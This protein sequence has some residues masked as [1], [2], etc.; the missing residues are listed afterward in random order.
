MHLLLKTDIGLHN[1]LITAEEKREMFDH[2]AD[3]GR[4]AKMKSVEDNKNFYFDQLKQL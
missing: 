2:V 4:V 3:D 1:I